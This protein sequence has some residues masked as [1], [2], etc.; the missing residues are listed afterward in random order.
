MGDNCHTRAVPSL[1]LDS[2]RPPSPLKATWVMDAAWPR[3]VSCNAP[4]AVSQK[5]SHEVVYPDGRRC[6]ID[7]GASAGYVILDIL[8]IWG[9]IP[10]I[11]DAATGNWKTLDADSCPGVM[12]D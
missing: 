7:S 6:I 9:L 12:V 2:T 8:F 11:V 1:P 3:T 4:L 10:I 5:R